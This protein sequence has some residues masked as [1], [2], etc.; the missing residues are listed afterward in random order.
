MKI[1]CMGNIDKEEE[2]RFSC[3]NCGCIWLANKN[4]YFKIS[5]SFYEGMKKCKCP[6]CGTT[7]LKLYY[8]ANEE[9]EKDR[10]DF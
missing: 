8:G 2:E 7:A 6:C 10:F 3:K 9:M 4:E 5:I 1:L